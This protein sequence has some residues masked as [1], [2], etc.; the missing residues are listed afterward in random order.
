MEIRISHASSKSASLT[1]AHIVAGAIFA[2]ISFAFAKIAVDTMVQESL[3]DGFRGRAFAAYDML[4][5]VA[6]VAGTAATAIAIALAVRESAIVLVVGLAYL[7]AAVG[8]AFWSS[9]LTV[10]GPIMQGIPRG[11]PARAAEA[12]PALPVGELVTIRSY[13]GSRADEEPR[14]IVVGEREIP[15]DAVD[16]RALEEREGVR[17]RIF[18]VRVAGQRVRLS[19][20]ESTSRWEIDRVIRGHAGGEALGDA[21]E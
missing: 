16:W 19:Y 1:K 13:A 8:S 4:Y 10:G 2:G 9:K 17:R 20:N 14:A 15:V 11:R 6:R 18:A 21:H 12:Q 7:A 3:P 5:N